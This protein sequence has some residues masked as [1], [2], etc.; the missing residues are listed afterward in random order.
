MNDLIDQFLIEAREL[1]Q[2]ATEDLLALE[3]APGDAEALN[4]VFRAFHTLKGSVG[5]FDFPPLLAL[6]HAAEDGLAASRAGTRAVDS[7]LIDLSLETLDAT[8]RWTDAIETTGCLPAGAA[9]EAAGL[10]VRFGGAPPPCAAPHGAASAA[11]PDWAVPLLAQA[12]EAPPGALLVAVR[13]RPRPD[14]F[15]SGED[16]LGLVRRLPGLL[17]LQIAPTAPWPS[18]GEVDVF[19][20]NLDIAL[21]TAAPR[22]EVDAVFR[23]VRDQVTVATVAGQARPAA[24]L[25]PLTAAILAEQLRLLAAPGE[26][27]GETGRREAAA[28]AAANALRAA[29][30]EAGAEACLRAAR[31]GPDALAR[32]LAGLREGNGAA[33]AADEAPGEAGRTLRIDAA[34]VEALVALAGDLVVARNRLGALAARAEAGQDGAGLARAL[35]E[36]DALIGRLVAELHRGVTALKLLPLAPVFQRFARPVREIARSLGKEVAFEVQGGQIGADKAVADALFEPLL[37]VIRN[38]VDHGLEHPDDRRRAGKP[39]A[40]RVVLRA[41]LIRD[42]LAVTVSDDGRGI[43]P[44]LVRR[45]AEARGLHAAEA[46]ATM[47]DAAATDLIFTPGLSTAE[48]VSDLSGRGVGMDAVRMAVERLGGQVSVESRVGQ[49]TTVRLLLPQTVALTRIMLV[50]VGPELYGVPL[51][52]VEEVAQVPRSRLRDLGGSGCATVLRGRTLPV[53]RLADLLGLPDAAPGGTAPARLLVVRAGT[54][55]AALEVDR[56]GE[57][58][59]VL[60]RPLTGLA[61]AAPGIASTTL[62]G[63]GRILLVLDPPALLG[64]ACGEDEPGGDA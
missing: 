5:L 48:S 64:L 24:A 49:G 34:R 32:L 47:S 50:A 12:D 58:L 63:D 53:L 55:T 2:S 26:P 27:G 18:D 60:T 15:Y 13:Y 40:G 7:A 31:E 6:L 25:P 23:L 57:R 37:H 45:R 56:F 4:R 59:D 52:A 3:A 38:A 29:G 17:A 1:I 28:R 21:L 36:S 10:V 11:P 35:R 54:G 44:A 19:T 20:C 22:Q 8:A 46:L 43:D 39:P 30:R 9:E 14:C 16:P 61:A 62:L 33:P 41:E 51:S 42:R